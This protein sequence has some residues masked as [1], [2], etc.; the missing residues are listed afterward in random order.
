MSARGAPWSP[1]AKAM[2][3]VPTAV[4]AS[5]AGVNCES[6]TGAN[7]LYESVGMRPHRV[8]DAWSRWL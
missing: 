3:A 1:W 2:N 8:I 7:H 4:E 6:P 5:A